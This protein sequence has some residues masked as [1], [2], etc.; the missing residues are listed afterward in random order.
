MS[1]F[2]TYDP[3]RVSVI[4]G[5]APIEGWQ[6]GEFVT[7]EMSSPMFTD[8]VG[9][10]GQVTR[11]KV[12][13]RTATVTV[14]IMQSSKSNDI[15]SG[16]LNADLAAPNGAGVVPFYMRDRS[17]RSLYTGVRCWVSEWPTVTMDRGAL[18]REW[19]IRVADME[20]FLGGN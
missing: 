17:G 9:V 20:M 14:K 3:D 7:I 2:Y 15:L 16:L 18:V 4:V 13:N 12:M 1:Q 6:D 11:S 8:V 10:D 5:A 19:K